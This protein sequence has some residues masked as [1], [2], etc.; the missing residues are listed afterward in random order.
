[1]RK[2][3]AALGLV[4]ASAVPAAG[5][6]GYYGKYEAP[7]YSVIGTYD[8]AELRAYDPY[9]VAVVAV[10]GE[11]RRALSRGFQVL[12]GYIF[13]GNAEGQSI[14]MTSPVTQTAPEDGVSE[15]TFM[16]PRGMAAD[17]MPAPNNAAVRFEEAGAERLLVLTFAG[18]A[19]EAVLQQRET[20]LR[21]IADRHGLRVVGAA[22]YSF[23]DDPMTLPMNRR[24]EVALPLGG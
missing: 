12:A 3:L 6:S 10:R 20:E 19:T 1:M 5:D 18:R 4:A 24:N 11:Q 17:A 9:L 23:Y 22:R 8:G 13:G 15:V 7:T 16:V 14:A 21:A 2:A